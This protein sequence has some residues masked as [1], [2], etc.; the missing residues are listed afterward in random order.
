MTWRERRTI[1]ILTTILLILSAML[2]IVLGIRYRQNRALPDSGENPAG[3]G[4][5]AAA[6]ST[7]FYTALSYSNGSTTLSFRQDEEGAWLWD[8]E[9][10]FPLDDTTVQ[11]ILDAL[12]G[13]K[14]QQ[15]LTDQ[16][17]LE[18]SGLS[19]STGYL[20]ATAAQGGA[21]TLLFGK[22][23]TDGTSCYVRLNGD[24]STVYIIDNAIQRLMDVPI[25][26]MCRL[27]ELPVLMESRISSISILGPAPEAEEDS[28]REAALTP[29]AGPLTILTAQHGDTA[30]WRSNGANVTGDPT[31]RGLMQNILNLRLSKCIDY[32][33][34]D[35]AAEIC[36]FDNPQ[37]TLR[38]RYTPDGQ[39]DLELLLT[40]GNR[41][42]DKSGR[43]TRLNGEAPIYLLETELLDPL[44]RVA[45]S[46]LEAGEA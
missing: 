6:A 32:D 1:T 26:D 35:E 23:T 30:S 46:G 41:L 24:E 39:E 21:T 14:P 10:D 44:M 33:P 29:A 12:T 4:G 13:W 38:I 27:P 43:Y 5:T 34:S 11:E 15:T 9:P 37:A 45:A 42:P 36:G 7:G 2:L 16:E 28:S 25:Y 8:A 31:V 18:A 40:I 22:A 3:P 20:T 17:S 19:E